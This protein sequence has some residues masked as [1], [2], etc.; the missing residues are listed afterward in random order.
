M[1]TALLDWGGD[2]PPV[3][4]H[5]ANGFCAATLHLVAQPLT[6]RFHVFGMDGRGHGDSS[7]PGGENPFDWREFGADIAAVARQLVDECGQ[8][9]ALG[10][11]H[12]FGGTCT[13]MAAAEEPGL[14]ER[15]FFVDP[16]LPLPP[17]FP[18]VADPERGARGS[19]L[20]AK[21]TKRR[22]VFPDRATAGAN[23]SPKPLF[24][25]WDARAF[26]LY[27]DEAL[28]D[29]PE[30]EVE[31][32][33]APTTEA[34]IF[35]QGMTHDVWSLLPKATMPTRIL[36]AE[37]G[38]FPEVLHAAYAEGL[39]LGSIETIDAGHLAPMETPD[40]VVAAV[41]AYLDEVD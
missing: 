4:M 6:E 28:R 32:K 34:A 21:A 36:W 12:S 8:P 29:T 30:G 23:W 17:H 15:L 1:E 10:F 18:T 35:S 22:A 27:L 25:N 31:L 3:L 39:P 20:I 41:F 5:H 26:Q 11:G 38:D 14:F 13:L 40:A 7:T 24:A 16:V 33:C 19:D 9:L 37:H 2:G